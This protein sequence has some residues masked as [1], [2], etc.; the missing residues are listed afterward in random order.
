MGPDNPAR[1]RIIRSPF[2]VL[3]KWLRTQRGVTQYSGR[4]FGLEISFWAE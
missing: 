3:E 4:I 1:A 2:K